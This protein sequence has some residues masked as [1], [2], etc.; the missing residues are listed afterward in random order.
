MRLSRAPASRPA[1]AEKG[2][3]MIIT[4]GFNPRGPRMLLICSA[5]STDTLVKPRALRIAARRGA[6]SL[7]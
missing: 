2:G 1:E 6:S 5:F 4:V 7:T 3:F